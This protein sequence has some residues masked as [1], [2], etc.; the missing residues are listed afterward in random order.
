MPLT[1]FQLS[2]LSSNVL[3]FSVQVVQSWL[4]KSI[5]E[6]P[7]TGA[8]LSSFGPGVMLETLADV[9]DAE[10][11]SC[12]SNDA[13]PELMKL[14]PLDDD[15]DPELELEP[16]SPDPSSSDEDPP[17]DAEDAD[18]DCLPPPVGGRL[19][20]ILLFNINSTCLKKVTRLLTLVFTLYTK[21]QILQGS[22]LTSY[23]FE[24]KTLSCFPSN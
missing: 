5:I 18:L 9:P 21:S 19:G 22:N 13:L 3:F 23:C 24:K 7:F 2:T 10:P 4:Q 16:S 14:E 12:T 11:T 1:D 6:S 15:P 20:G 8:S 17:P